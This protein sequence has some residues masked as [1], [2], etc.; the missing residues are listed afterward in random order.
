MINA[1]PEPAP[2]TAAKRLSAVRQRIRAA[3]KAAGRPEESVSLLAVSKTWDASRVLE[4]AALGQHQ[5]GENYLQEA[6]AKIADCDAARAAAIE[7]HFIG[8]IQSNKTRPIAE[9]FH[10]VH[11]I[12]REKIAARLSEQWP[13]AQPPLQVC[14]QVNVSGESS[15]SGCSPDEAVALSLA[16]ARLP[17]LHL[18][19]LM[20]I[21]EP[22]DD[23]TLQ[24]AR[25][26]SLRQIFVQVQ[27]ALNPLGREFA[28]RF[29][30]LSMGMSDDLEAAVAEGATIV[31]V[32]TA[33]FG[34]RPAAIR[35][36]P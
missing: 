20:T 11:S 22:T 8:P 31:R 2:G 32:G 25:F 23:M 13:A 7:W 12:E 34:R 33:L 5:F 30:T 6:L 14:V 17:R 26:T 29:D 3:C 16:V 10:W 27:N 21:P 19:G 18:R 28:D 15:K 1:Q 4:L 36:L 24:R 35:P 9:H